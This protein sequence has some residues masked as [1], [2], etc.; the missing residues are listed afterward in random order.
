[1][2]GVGFTS[3]HL[4]LD[5]A[6]DFLRH[7][8]SPGSNALTGSRGYRLNFYRAESKELVSIFNRNQVV[9]STWANSARQGL[10]DQNRDRHAQLVLLVVD[11][12]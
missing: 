10:N 4:Q 2:A 5:E 9:F 12:F 1:M 11:L 8:S 6:D 7:D 3:R